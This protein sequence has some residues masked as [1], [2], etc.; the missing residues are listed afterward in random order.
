MISK[1]IQ[2]YGA[3]E[4][5]ILEVTKNEMKMTTIRKKRVLIVKNVAPMLGIFRMNI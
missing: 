3:Y 2:C 5:M 1:E 4:E